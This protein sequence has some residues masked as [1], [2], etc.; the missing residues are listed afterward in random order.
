MS[1]EQMIDQE[2]AISKPLP[3]KYAGFWM[4][5]WAY[6]VDLIIVFSINGLLI[7]PYRILTDGATYEIGF[8]TVAAIIHTIIIYG[9]FVLLTKYF[10]QT[11]GKRIFG[12]K[13]IREDGLPLTWSDLLFREVVG[14]FL[15]RVL[16]ITNA[17]YLVVA[18]DDEKR[19]VHDMIGDTRVIHE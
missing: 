12:L 15:H 18:F 3:V 4:R 5:F 6:I 1:T 16:G 10:S 7:A 8:W 14:R 13:V 9:Y 17:L 19:G 2:Q 11:I